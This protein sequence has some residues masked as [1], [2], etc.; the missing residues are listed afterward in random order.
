[1]GALKTINARSERCALNVD[2][3]RRVCPVGPT[4]DDASLPSLDVSI[5]ITGAEGEAGSRFVDLGLERL[6]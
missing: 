2:L 4:D 3:S 6:N 5:S 1:M